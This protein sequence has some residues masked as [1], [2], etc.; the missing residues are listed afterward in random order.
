MSEFKNFD[1]EYLKTLCVPKDIFDYV[2]TAI[3]EYYKARGFKFTK[4]PRKMISW[5][6]EKLSHC[7]VFGTSGTNVLP[8]SVWLEIN[9]ANWVIGKEK[10]GALRF[11]F[12]RLK[13]REGQTDRI[14][15]GFDGSERHYGLKENE[16]P[17]ITM[18]KGC[19]IYAL[20]EKGFENIIKYTDRLI[21]TMNSLDTSE[22]IE[23][24]LHG[25][26]DYV[27]CYVLDDIK[28]K[29]YIYDIRGLEEC[30]AEEVFE[31]LIK[32]Y[33]EAI[34]WEPV[35]FSNKTLVAELKS[36]IGE[37]DPLY[38]EEIYAVAK[39]GSRDDVLFVTD[40]ENDTDIY[41]IYHLT[42]SKTNT[43][44]FPRYKEF[45]GIKEV[46]QYIVNEF[47]RENENE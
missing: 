42:Y 44:G 36:E 37:N 31:D 39:R 7:L 9:A 22:G 41:R 6:S 20:D 13:P 5:K 33:G 3:G 29:D 35:A 25:I 47:M 34:D 14:V 2:C 23:K 38:S 15:I 28:T 1:A 18:A 10:E 21:E 12:E 46:K 8:E 11:M 45:K 24:Y 32:R 26:P 19:N 40:N 30:T 43:E 16:N 4:S 27:Y 17:C